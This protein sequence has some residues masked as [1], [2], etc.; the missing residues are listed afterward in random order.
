MK[1][2]TTLEHLIDVMEERKIDVIFLQET[3]LEGDF[4]KIVNNYRI[5]HHGLANMASNRGERG[6]AIT[7]SPTI[8]EAHKA[9][10]EELSLTS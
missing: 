8:V 10:S 7:L 4:I 6:V 3:W 9:N 1:D 5:I 2:S